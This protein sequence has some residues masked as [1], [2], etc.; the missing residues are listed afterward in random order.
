VVARL[1]TATADPPE[2]AAAPGSTGTPEIERA[3]YPPELLAAG[4]VV[5][6]PLA[7]GVGALGCLAL[8]E[9]EIER[10][11]IEPDLALIDA[12]AV[13]ASGALERLV[14]V[15][16]AAEEELR[17]RRQEELDRRK[18]E[19]LSQVAH[20][21]QTPLTSILWS[22]QNL[23][24]GIAGPLAPEA[25]A[26][27]GSI[28]A[29]GSH[30]SRL[31]SNLVAL[32]RLDEGALTL[33]PE[34]VPLL[35]SLAEARTALLPLAEARAVRIE[36]AGNAEAPSW[37]PARSD[38]DGLMKIAI[39]LL[40]NAIKYAPAGSTITLRL[41]RPAPGWLSFAV[42]DRGPGVPVAHRERIF[43]R[44]ARGPAAPDGARRG[45]GL[46]L[47]VARAYLEGCGGSI[48]LTETCGGGATFTCTLREFGPSAGEVPCPES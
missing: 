1:A 37:P 40:D 14:L 24:D 35:G 29:A 10:R 5:M 34:P 44:Y 32:A 8:G 41:D 18:A 19:F 28:R 45:F 26:A 25:A 33:S 43:E 4:L 9:K 23:L 15:R 20:D 42:E 12:V 27:V 31:V 13:E 39:N 2:T 7:G 46:G 48:T 30:L 38:R 36:L 22:S 6:R 47:F 11:F 3:D 21:L 17:V 16:R